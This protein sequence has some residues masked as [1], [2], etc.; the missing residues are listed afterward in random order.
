MAPVNVDEQPIVQA[1]LK[2][3][4][5]AQTPAQQKAEQEWRERASK[6]TELNIKAVEGPLAELDAHLTLRS[7]ISGYTISRADLIV[8]GTLRSNRVAASF[9]KTG[10]RVN[11][12]RWY[13]FIESDA[14]PFVTQAVTDT[15]NAKNAETKKAAAASTD[16]KAGGDDQVNFDIGLE[17]TS[18]GVVTRFPPEPSGYLHIGHAKAALLNDYF[19]HKKYKGTLLLR[20]DDTNPL[21]EKQEFEDS[22]VEDLALMGVTPDKTTHTSD[23][24]QELYEYC[25]QMLKEGTAY[26]DDTAQEKMRQERMDGIASAR[27]EMT[28]ED[29]LARFEEMKAGTEEGKKWFIRAKISADNPNKAMRDPVIYRCSP[30]PHHRTGDT[31]K[32]YPTYDFCCP[33]VDSLE[34]VTHALR[35]TEYLDRDAQYQWMLKALRLRNVYNWDFARLNMI[36]TL[37]SKRKLTKIVDEGK[38]WGWDDPRMP[39]VRGIRRRGMTI[40]ALQEFIL[41]Q[42]PSRNVV[43]LDWTTIWATNKKY[44]DPTASRYTA[45]AKRD[46]VTVHV[47]GFAHPAPY[48]EDRPKHAKYDLGNKKVWFSD[49]IVIEQVD[50]AELAE[51][52]E[53][54]LMNWGN[55]IV[56]SISHSIN[57]VKAIAA[58][59]QDAQRPVA[60]VN[61]DLNLQGD[62]KTT[63]K[64]IHWLATPDNN[65]QELIPVE[66]VDFDYL[67]TKD[68]LEDDD[69]L[70]DFLTAQTEFRTDCVADCNVASLREGDIMQF[71]RKGYFRVD[72]PFLHGQPAVLFQIP[73]GKGGK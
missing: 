31:W 10:A 9:T 32:I 46:M 25:V 66:C 18:A 34:G 43:N 16:K 20:F 44:I 14:H 49:T 45:I 48:A 61:V 72:R 37:M 40:P 54:T 53:I 36:R 41:K 60:S 30:Q 59:V 35:T 42:G 64:K 11:L 65:G 22:I 55:A 47:T 38:V 19:A 4:L 6:L 29:S 15:H 17:D 24:F 28:P 2:H 67:I 39:T 26:A 13:S 1:L 68:K 21:K 58:A 27:R 3:D 73:T 56:R 51:G 8:W 63:K 23:Y 12:S 52:E 50:A 62:V 5:P 57:P 33:I 70:E 71:D 69:K 7:Y